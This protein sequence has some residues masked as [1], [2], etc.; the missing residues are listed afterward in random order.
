M[1]TCPSCNSSCDDQLLVCPVCGYVFEEQTG[2]GKRTMMGF[3]SMG[4]KAPEREPDS[5]DPIKQT[6]FGFPANK[7]EQEGEDSRTTSPDAVPIDDGDDDTNIIPVSRLDFIQD[8]MRG[9]VAGMRAPGV[10]EEDEDD[11]DYGHDKTEIVSGSAVFAASSSDGEKV[12]GTLMG[13]SLEEIESKA[14][15][16]DQQD[17][18]RSTRFAIPAVQGGGE[19]DGSDDSL[20]EESSEPEES[21]TM[22]WNPAEEVE[23]EAGDVDGRKALLDKIRRSRPSARDTSQGLPS[24]KPKETQ[25]GMAPVGGGLDLSALRKLKPKRELAPTPAE[26]PEDNLHETVEDDAVSARGDTP[27]QGVVRAPKRPSAPSADDSNVS[28]GASSYMMGPGEARSDGKS[29]GVPLGSIRGSKEGAGIGDAISDPEFAY[30][31]TG[32]AD[33]DVVREAVRLKK[34]VDDETTLPESPLPDVTGKV[35][36]P[37][38]PASP[39]STSSGRIDDAAPFD[40]RPPSTPSAP[41]LDEPPPTVQGLPSQQ[42]PGTPAG[43]P[44]SSDI[45][46]SSPFGQTGQGSRQPFG[47]QNQYQP[48]A[49][50]NSGPGYQPEDPY[51]SQAGYNPQGS[52]PGY[53]SQGGY[54]GQDPYNPPSAGYNQQQDPYNPPSQPYAQQSNPYG[55]DPTGGQYYNDPSGPAPMQTMSGTMSGQYEDPLVRRIQSLFG[56]LAGLVTLGVAA[57]VLVGGKM[58][59][60]SKLSLFLVAL[61]ITL[62]VAAI[63]VS[64]LPASARLKTIGLAALGLLLFLLLIP[65]PSL[66]IPNSFLALSV[67]A[68]VC[69]MAAFF[70]RIARMIL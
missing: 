21:P 30:A 55:Q 33:L 32:V 42:R 7:E 6:L 18:S 52:Q 17:G 3:P 57:V 49:G 20:D 16:E 39:F 10:P 34:Q 4:G 22:A 58:P 23:N 41:S 12:K 63:G 40:H 64:L 59:Q 29:A 70:P 60:D 13:M 68:F 9:T 43:G 15:R 8:S 65:A 26:F 66:G 24:A 11:D 69:F 44:S 62:G 46:H 51:G 48:S 50:F 37:S 38:Q 27:A 25:R 61:A 19:D 31:E 35:T 47:E 2:G 14:A 45:S 28:A 1:K 67:G 56:F 36:P 54:A 5:R 53:Q